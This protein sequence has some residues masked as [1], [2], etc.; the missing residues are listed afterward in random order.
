M[1]IRDF[2]KLIA[3]NGKD[4]K[5]EDFDK[6]GDGVITEKEYNSAL[7]EYDLDKVELSKIDNNQD[8]NLTQDEFQIWEQKIEM[9]EALQPYLAKVI[10]DFTGKNSKYAAE[11][12]T[13]LRELI[14]ELTN[15]YVNAGKDICNLAAEFLSVL[16]EKYETMKKNILENTPESVK[17]R[18]ID[19]ILLETKN[20]LEL[21]NRET[22]KIRRGFLGRKTNKK[23][24]EEIVPNAYYQILGNALEKAAIKFIN[25]YKGENLEVDLKRYL[26]EYINTSD[27]QKMADAVKE[28]EA[29]V[30][31]GD[32]YIDAT[33]FA[34]L[35]NDAKKLLKEALNNG[36]K[37][38]IDGKELKT[39][40][41]IENI[42]ASYKDA[43]KLKSDIKGFI[44]NLNE[45]TVL[46]N[47]LA[48]AKEKNAAY[49][50]S[51]FTSIS[52]EEYKIDASLMDFNKIEGYFENKGM[53]D[54]RDVSGGRA[55][56]DEKVRKL[57]N[58]GIREQ[59]FSQISNMLVSKGIEPSKI[60]NVFNNVFDESVLEV[61]SGVNLFKDGVKDVVT[62]FI[63][64]FNTKI[65]TAID[66]MNQSNKDFDVSDIDMGEVAANAQVLGRVPLELVEVMQTGSNIGNIGILGETKVER[67]YC[68]ALS[69][70][71]KPQVKQKARTM[72]EV[73]GI[74]FDEKVFTA[75]YENAIG[76]VSAETDMNPKNF[77]PNAFVR[78]I[79]NQFKLDYTNWVDKQK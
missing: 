63:E 10:Q 44:E 47:V 53:F 45:N 59:M 60:K 55:A 33:E 41:A 7:K 22:V 66:E 37:I 67:D 54:W 79:V 31:N 73:N 8:K 25:N 30:N 64:I 6:D 34:E 68:Q 23:D 26:Q 78:K 32:I 4:V 74:N 2:G 72:C 28:Y 16:P 65:V 13:S 19:E 40:S 43:E 36:I 70:G 49:E 48:Q 12:T 3:P 77:N 15:V 51:K 38:E 50:Q 71:L 29:A 61:A 69:E 24:N 52:G 27:K 35:K 1:E 21:I 5:F 20:E 11:M 39:V 46:E 57:L 76:M 17:S 75:M 14:D 58:E 42:I 56:R 9:E 18:V 62:N